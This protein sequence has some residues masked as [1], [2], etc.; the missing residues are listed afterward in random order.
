MG[1]LGDNG[2]MEVMTSVNRAYRCFDKAKRLALISTGTSLEME[3]I[4]RE[5]YK[6]MSFD[7]DQVPFHLTLAKVFRQCLDL[8]SA[9]F[10]YRFVL[11]LDHS[12]VPARKALAELLALKGKE[13]MLIGQ[14]L[15]LKSKFIAARAHFDEALEFFRENNDLWILK[16]ICHVHCEELAEAWES[17]T[18]VIKP[19]GETPAEY[20]ILRAKIN[21]GRGLVEQ[22]NQDIR[23][24]LS[25]DPNHPEVVGFIARSYAKSEKLYKE[26]LEKFTAR[27]YKDALELIDHA[28]YI[29]NDDVKLHLMKAKL[30]RVMEDLQSAYEAVLKAKELFVNSYT[31][32]GFCMNLP[33]EI[34]KQINLILNEMALQYATQGD[35]HN[36]IL[37]LNRIIREEHS[38]EAMAVLP[39]DNKYYVNRADC[40]RALLQLHEAIVDYQ[41]ALALDPHDW[42]IKTKMSLTLYLLATNDFNSS[43]FRDADIG[44]TKAIH[45]NPKVAEY[46]ALRG[47][48]RYYLGAFYEA[49]RDFRKVL[50]LDPQNVEILERIKQFDSTDDFQAQ[51][52][53]A[54]KARAKARRLKKAQREKEGMQMADSDDGDES[55]SSE[56]EENEEKKRK[57]RQQQAKNKSSSKTN[58]SSSGGG[59]SKE[60]EDPQTLP[61]DTQHPNHSSGSQNKA[62]KSAAQLLIARAR[63]HAAHLDDL[64]FQSTYQHERAVW[65][66]TPTEEDQM[67]MMLMPHK[68]SRLPTLKLLTTQET[69]AQPPSAV[70]TSLS[71]GGQSSHQH[72]SANRSQTLPAIALTSS[73][74]DAYVASQRV[75]AK[76]QEVKRVFDERS[77]LSKG[78]SWSIVATAMENAKQN[79]K[80][81]STKRGNKR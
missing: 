22:G 81:T 55:S 8:T 44:L 11:K 48:A 71:Q 26:A 54:K 3:R 30:H 5:I 21:W 9:M 35:Y 32:G 37:L 29:T 70:R 64:N 50:K 60:G 20:F 65:H 6:A 56:D 19:N 66:L 49:Y 14:E 53:L 80:V 16:A 1:D 4:L 61:Q 68:A 73:F 27:K 62:K 74:K 10:C 75:Q 7:S 23:A 51:R 47:R 77:D 36:A 18:K 17:V 79:A 43:H 58:H 42:Q 38:A 69:T 57:W 76:A 31:E 12:N 67:K 59:N 28:L 72:T 25:L 41:S 40:F 52:Q 24:A 33:H 63:A 13:F 46:Y 2:E 34:Q 39:M 45:Y 78:A 15:N